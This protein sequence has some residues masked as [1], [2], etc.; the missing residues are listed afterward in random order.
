[1]RTTLPAMDAILQG[2]DFPHL[3]V[4]EIAA[5]ADD[6]A[7][8]IT[9]GIHPKPYDYVDPNEDVVAVVREGPVTALIVAD[10]HNG[11][12]ASHA[13]VDG[14]LDALAQPLPTTW[15]P[16]EIV[17]CFHEANEHLR[18]VRRHGRHRFSRS[19]LVMAYVITNGDGSRI[20]HAAS[21]GDSAVIVAG[22]GQAR[23]LTTDRHRF[24]GDRLSLPEVAGSLELA[25]ASLAP[26]ETVIV[27]SD[28]FTN[29]APLEAVPDIAAVGDAA[30][31]TRQLIALAGEGGAGDNVA[32]AVLVTQAG[33]WIDTVTRT[34]E[35]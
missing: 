31:R 5:P 8:G 18:T 26:G 21:I 22:D 15:Q 30:Q 19:T 34:G 35:Q 16:R 20:V 7:L 28:G 6:L 27:V 9:R 11:H 32:A 13:A 3:G 4:V 33:S 25:S 24:L 2:R 23:Q 29:F 12:E 10:G 17:R 14:L 1:M